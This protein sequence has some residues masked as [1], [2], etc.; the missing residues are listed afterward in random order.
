MQN[1]IHNKAINLFKKIDKARE[2]YLI[3]HYSC[4]SFYDIKDGKT[5]RIT[6]IAIFQY[7]KLPKN[8]KF[9]LMRSKPIMIL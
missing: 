8:K 3:I 5:P 1:D 9:N 2:N 7:T 4:E 6:S